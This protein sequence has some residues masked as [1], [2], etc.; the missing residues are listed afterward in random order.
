MEALPLICAELERKGLK[1]VTLSELAKHSE[2]ITG[3]IPE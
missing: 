2:P 3:K 1:M